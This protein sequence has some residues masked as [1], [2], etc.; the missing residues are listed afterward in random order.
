[1]PCNRQTKAYLKGYYFKVVTDHIPL[2]WLHSLEN[3][4]GTVAS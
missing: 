4:S 1:M 2:K 3:P